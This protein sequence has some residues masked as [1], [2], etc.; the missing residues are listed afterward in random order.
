MCLSRSQMEAKRMTLAIAKKMNFAA[1]T[2]SAAAKCMILWLVGIPFFPPPEAHRAAR[3]IVPSMHHNSLLIASVLRSRSSMQSNVPSPFHL[4]NRSHT[5]AHG[6]NSSGKSRQG[7]PVLR[8]H[9]IPSTIARRSRGGR[10]VCLGGSNKSEIKLH[11]SSVSRCR[12]ITIPFVN[13]FSM[14]SATIEVFYEF[15]DRA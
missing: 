3:T 12:N 7:A 10:P 9:K 15:S 14:T 2:A 4:S 6:P 11:C 5:V 8:I 13:P 1:Q